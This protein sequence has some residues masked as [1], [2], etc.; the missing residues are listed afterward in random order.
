MRA[1]ESH[2]ERLHPRIRAS[3]RVDWR[4]SGAATHVVSNLAN[5][6]AGG[7]MVLTSFAAEVGTPIELHLLT[8]VGP[9][10]ARGKVAWAD[11]ES[12]GITFEG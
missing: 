8:E 6:S 2:Y 9:V 3:T 4:A 7:A 1:H 11:R 5:V 10:A 12:M